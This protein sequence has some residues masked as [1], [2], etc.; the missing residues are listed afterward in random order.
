MPAT[1]RRNELARPYPGLSTS[2]SS[3]GV[4]VLAVLATASGNIRI[5][6]VA[7]KWQLS[8]QAQT[9][10]EVADGQGRCGEHDVCIAPRR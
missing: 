3:D 5:P 8:L 6:A 2:V 4:H 1:I 10:K 9:A 7:T